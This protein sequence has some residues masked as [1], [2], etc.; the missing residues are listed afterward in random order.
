MKVFFYTETETIHARERLNNVL[1]L[2]RSANS[3][4]LD[5]V[6]SAEDADAII[7]MFTEPEISYEDAIKTLMASEISKNRPNDLFV[8]DTFYKPRGYFPGFYCSLRRTLF[9]RSRHRSFCY[10]NSFNEFVGKSSEDQETSPDLFF[11]FQGNLTSRVR[12]KIFSLDIDR[13]DVL[14]EQRPPIWG[15]DIFSAKF[16]HIKKVTRK[17]FAEAASCFAR[18]A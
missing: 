2:W 5:V 15:P 17:R 18:A 9:D 14:V 10:L 16:H 1:S 8:W 3:T 13:K 4:E 7:A 6:G 11:S 12:G